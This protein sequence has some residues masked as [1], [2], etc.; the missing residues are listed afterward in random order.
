MDT[1]NLSDSFWKGSSET[2]SQQDGGVEAPF[3]RSTAWKTHFPTV[4]NLVARVRRKLQGLAA[5]EEDPIVAVRGLGYRL[6]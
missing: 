1:L 3:R 5:T 4:G 2:S 6:P